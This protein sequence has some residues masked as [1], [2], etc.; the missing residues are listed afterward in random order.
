MRQT[1][2]QRLA[3]LLLGTSVLDWL[4]ARIHPDEPPS[5]RRLANE[6]GKATNGQIEVT[7]EAIRQWLD[8]AGIEKPDARAGSAA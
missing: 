7:G 8:A 2:N 1:P 3:S 6:L 4:S 5:Y